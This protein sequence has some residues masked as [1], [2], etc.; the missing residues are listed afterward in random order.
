MQNN[1][2]DT[3]SFYNNEE[4]FNK[5]LGQTSYYLGLQNIVD[6][7]V[8]LTKAS[9]VLELGAA[10]GTT[11]IR[12]GMKYPQVSFV[13]TDIR[14]DVI[15]TANE[16]AKEYT[17]ITFFAQDMCEQVKEDLSEYDLIFQLY[18][19]HH[20]LDPLEKKTEFL[21]D[22]YRNM[23]K[24]AYLLIAETFLPETV[25]N[26]KDDDVILD[27]WKQRSMEGY[28]S[29]YWAALQELTDEG[30]TFAQKVAQ[31]SK[32]EEFEA[33]KHVY[34]RDDEYLV[35]FSW[36]KEEAVKSGFEIVIAEPVNALEENV[37]LLRK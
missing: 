35:K 30:I 32:E 2:K 17:N 29:T 27:L 6:K 9:R 14:E 25:E 3:P 22:C 31:T 8:A 34:D 13:G 15:K 21:N 26:L 12:L 37:I 18:A 7:T 1:Y 5:Y 36:L 4:Y 10:L 28:A 19:F 20:I 23:K 11:T 16:N 33:G 24:G